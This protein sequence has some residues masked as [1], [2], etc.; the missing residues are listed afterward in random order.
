MVFEELFSKQY[1]LKHPFMIFLS[2]LAFTIFGIGGSII[3][4]KDFNPSI[5]ALA[6]IGL[7][8]VDSFSNTL[9]E[10]KNNHWNQFKESL[11]IYLFI[12][13]GVFIGY[14]LF[15][16]VLPAEASNVIFQTQFL[17]RGTMDA[18]QLFFQGTFSSMLLNNLGVLAVCL[19]VSIIFGIETFFLFIVLWNASVFG[20][21][22][23]SIASQAP[24]ITGTN[25][26]FTL[27]VLMIMAL[28]HLVLEISA[29]LMSGLVGSN[30]SHKLL[31]R[32]VPLSYT[33]KLLVASIGLIILG[34]LFEY[35]FAP[36][37]G[38]WLLA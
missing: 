36:Q 11:L 9:L 38:L 8:L 25:P 2:A 23:G 13:A 27:V 20:S 3:L 37:V 24:I 28:P 32:K 34:V 26:L 19:L 35:F 33:M 29:Y 14:L 12:F 17:E 7:M 5:I 1:L 30:V 18:T 10:R 6:L 31:G 16:F 15:G 4:F 22:F 21:I